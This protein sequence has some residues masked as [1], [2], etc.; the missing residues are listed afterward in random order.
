MRV[1]EAVPPHAASLDRRRAPV[2]QSRERVWGVIRPLAALRT[3]VEPRNEL[4]WPG[5]SS[6]PRSSIFA[7]PGGRAREVG[8]ARDLA[9]GHLRRLRGQPA[10][11]VHGRRGERVHLVPA[12]RRRVDQGAEGRRGAAEGRAGARGHHLPA[13]VRADRGRP[14][15]DHQ[16]RRGAVEEALQGG[17]GRRRRPPRPAASRAIGAVR[18]AGSRPPAPP[19][20]RGAR[21]PPRLYR[22]SR[23]TTARS[24]GRSAR[25]TARP[26]S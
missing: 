19:R 24:S 23:P 21:D 9:G 4:L 1:R 10:G 15:D 5:R 16:G 22:A 6:R 2:S 12:R 25:P 18:R 11:Q 26:P 13:R 14:G 8:R 7:I 20:R 17:G 3:V